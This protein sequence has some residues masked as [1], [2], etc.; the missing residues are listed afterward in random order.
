MRRQLRDMSLSCQGGQVLLGPLDLDLEAGERVGLMGE[1][2][3][4][5]SLLGQ[6]LVG[7]LPVGVR[8]GGKGPAMPIPGLPEDRVAWVPQEP[9]R[10][11]HPFLTVEEHLVLLP[12]VRL[13]ERRQSSRARLLPLLERLCLPRERSFLRRFPHQI[14]GGQRQRLVL[15]MAL[16]WDPAFLILDEPT[17]AL[18]PL[19]RWEL[20]AL[21]EER[22]REQGLGYLWISHDLEMLSKAT[23][24]LLV[25]YGGLLV[26]AG[27]TQRVLKAPRSPYT[28]R[29]L[30][31]SRGE[32]SLDSGYLQAPEQRQPGCP[33]RP[34]CSDGLPCCGQ[35]VGW[36]GTLADGFRCWNPISRKS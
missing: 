8:V 10:G 20:F 33:F 3:S 4:G 12:K 31:A 21:L 28:L 11:L 14:S 34:R 18:D 13:G 15:A 6:V 36:Q 24:R 29:L 25:I 17:T 16:S 23:D 2:G 30:G 22:N 32:A 7:I 1:S 27:P 5:K 9:T 35:G 19:A 26:E